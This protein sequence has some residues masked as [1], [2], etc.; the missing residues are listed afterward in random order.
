MSTQGNT[1]QSTMG[2]SGIFTYKWTH[3]VLELTAGGMG[4]TS[5]PAA[6]LAAAGVTSRYVTLAE[7]YYAAEKLQWKLSDRNYAFEKAGWE[8]NRF[9][10][11]DARVDGTAGLG[12]EL[13]KTEVHN[14]ILEL[15][16]GYVNEQRMHADRLQFASGRSY[17]RYCLVLSPTSSFSQ[18]GEYLHDFQHPKGYR[19]N[20][21]SALV[22]TISTH[23]SLKVSYGY[24]HVNDPVAGFRRDD[25]L[26]SAALI[27]NY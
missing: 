23:I 8:K 2:A 1:N 22:S 25:S 20:A 27:V 18:D 13:V 9:A 24:K 14:L 12:R 5:K 26:T 17:A 7:Q 19:G 21:E 6:T 3:T 4:A 10:G 15:G 16:G 11:I